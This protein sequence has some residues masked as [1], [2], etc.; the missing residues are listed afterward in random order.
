MVDSAK[1]AA[2]DVVEQGKAA[3]TQA[4]GDALS[5]KGSL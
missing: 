2:G 3:V 5:A 1:A 4:V